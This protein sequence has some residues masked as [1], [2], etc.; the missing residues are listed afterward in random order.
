A[1]SLTHSLTNISR[2]VV[3]SITLYTVHPLVIKTLR[4]STRSTTVQARTKKFSIF[5]LRA[6]VVMGS[7][8]KTRLR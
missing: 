1:T 4:T 6:S 7:F 2:L 8:Y 5:L 3:Q